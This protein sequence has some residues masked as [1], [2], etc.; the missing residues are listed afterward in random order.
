MMELPVNIKE[1]SVVGSDEVGVGDYLGPLV[2]ASVYIDASQINALAAIGV[3][4]SKGL[5]DKRICEIAE[6]IKDL[7]IFKVVVFENK[8]YNAMIEKG[9][10]AHVVKSFLHNKAIGELISDLPTYPEYI[11][12]DEFASKEHHLRYLNRLPK[13]P[14]IVDQN[15]Y[16]VKKGETVH[17]AVAAASIL[18]REAFVRYMD[19]L[20]ERY[21][22]EILKGASAKV[23]E[24]GVEFMAQHGEATFKDI[25]KWHFANTKRVLD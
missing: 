17:V 3:R 24:C 16:F 21:E 15:L 23:D 19:D 14:E 5:T 12:V 10:N 20:S 6:Q 13:K 8:Y 25:C 7:V 22:M 9:L 18:A 4:D 1:L 11:I 2:V